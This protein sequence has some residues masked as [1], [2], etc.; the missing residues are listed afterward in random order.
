M[1]EH[2]GIGVPRQYHELLARTKELGFGMPSDQATG[3]LLRCLAA[4]KPGGR[5][6]EL[7]TGTGLGTSWLLDGMDSETRLDSVESEGRWLEV[8]RA[9]LGADSRLTLF[10]EDGLEFLKRCP[11]DTYDLIF[12]DTWPGKFFGFEHTLRIMRRG[13][14]LV[15]DDL[16]PQPNWPADHPP[17]V[18]RLLEHL[19]KL[20]RERFSVVKLWWQTGH[21]L[22]TKRGW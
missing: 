3:V 21:V 8:A 1:N 2:A 20:P 4:S 5:A 9:C 22:L 11:N 6:L 18:A 14:I 7:G 16:L 12:A 13:G 10:C 19:D 15:L 17:K